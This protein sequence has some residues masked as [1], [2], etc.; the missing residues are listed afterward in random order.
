VSLL[1]VRRESASQQLRRGD[2]RRRAALRFE[3]GEMKRNA[4]AAVELEE[5]FNV[6]FAHFTKLMFGMA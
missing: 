1:S 6:I 4:P 5:Y 2:G 3:T